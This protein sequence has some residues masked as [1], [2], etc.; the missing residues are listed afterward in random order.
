MKQTRIVYSPWSARA[1]RA[2]LKTMT[3]RL[4]PVAGFA[5][6]R[7]EGSELCAWSLRLARPIHGVCASHSGG[8]FT[9]LQAASIAAA[10]FCQYGQPG[11]ILVP[12]E[13]WRAPR[14]FDARKPVDIPAGT[15]I[16][17]DADGHAPDGFGRYRNARFMPAHL[18]KDR[19]RL[20]AVRLERLQDIS[21]DDAIAEGIVRHRKGG[22][23]V[24]QPP[25][26][27]EGTNHFGFKTARDAYGAVWASLHGD[28]SWAA[29]PWVWVLE[30]KRA[31]L[32]Q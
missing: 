2:G 16:W 12:V 8:R 20:V 31:E 26:G 4:A 15:P 24:E 25:A 9:D 21:E 14:E 13:A 29:N 7:A 22:W 11:D 3:R 32:A 10:R 18:V 17:R 23:H 5:I 27:I 19:D 30:F 28:A 1:R 6:H